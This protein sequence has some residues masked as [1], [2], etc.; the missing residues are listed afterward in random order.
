MIAP[1]RIL[2]AIA[3]QSL[4][5]TA[6]PVG[7]CLHAYGP[8]APADKIECFE[9]EKVERAGDNYRFFPRSDKSVV[10]NAY[11]FRGTIPYKANLAPTHPEFDKLLKLYEE[12]ARATPS[13]R[14][15]LNHRILAMRAQAA[16]VAKQ[17]E[18]LAESLTLTLADGSK[19]VG[20][21]M[22][23][24]DKGFVSI[25]HQGG[26][27]KVDIKELD[28]TEKKALTA[29]A[30]GLSFE[31]PSVTPKDSS[32]TFAKIVFKNG[33]RLKKAQFKEVSGGNL[34]FMADGKSVSVPADQFP[35]DLSVFGDEVLKALAAR[36]L[37]VRAGEE[38][39]F[40]IAAGVNMTFCWIPPGEFVTDIPIDTIINTRDNVQRRVRLTQGYWLAK[41]EVTQAQWRAVMGSDPSRFRGADL[42]VEQVSWNDICGNEER[43][44]GFLG[45]IN[46]N[47]SIG[48]RFDLPTQAQ[49]EHACRAGTTGPYAGDLDS[50]AWYGKN[51]GNTT[52]PV[53]TKKPNAWGLHDMHGN[54]GE[55]CANWSDNFREKVEIDPQGPTTGDYRVICGGSWL[56]RARFCRASDGSAQMPGIQNYY[57]G[58]RPA[59]IPTVEGKNVPVLSDQFPSEPSVAGEE[60]AKP[61][62]T[63]PGEE[64]DFEIAPGVTM[65]F[66]WIPAGEFLMG[67]PAGE[68]GRGDDETQHRVKLTQG[69]WLAKTEVTQAQWRAGGGK[70]MSGR[71]P[72][73][74]DGKEPS[75]WERLELRAMDFQGENLPVERVDWSEAR[76]WCGGMG[77]RLRNDG[78]LEAGWK[79]ALP[80][81]AQWEYACRAGKE[82]ALNNGRNLTNKEG[83]CRNLDEVAWYDENSGGDKTHPVGGKQPNAWGL[84]DMHGNVLEWCADWSDDY[85][86]GAVTDP[87][88][89]AT[90][91]YRVIRGGS[92][93]L[94]AANCRAAY[95]YGFMP[96]SRIVFIGFR[97]AIVPSE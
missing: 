32:G 42:P 62:G 27:S 9:F 21:K 6:E 53:G 73:Q 59:L 46:A 19:L 10:V 69:Y 81:E 94:T 56:M 7:I 75:T 51:S 50:M 76:D 8:D 3:I 61:L 85:P 23:K 95:R 60:T 91:D 24:I 78:V 35:G 86:G 89:P 49:W 30:D 47:A 52:H 25:M 77:E 5:A 88:G 12:T 67:S 70:D 45:K 44:G 20:C 37:G 26:I 4:I 83:I 82:T 2:I 63:K 79:V 31:D 90:G 29:T 97:P 57:T 11:R 71:A 96:V 72:A 41:T 74:L 40:E 15:F 64:R 55:W 80:T 65:T 22:T 38:R 93:S 16:G 84:Y 34:V 68:L 17:T 92:W 33:V 66:C 58:F 13:T 1:L 14:V 28:D 87:K 48:M 43:A 36:A 39:D 54:V 18:S